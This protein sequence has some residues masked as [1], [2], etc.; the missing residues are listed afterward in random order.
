MTT[1]TNN[2]IVLAILVSLSALVSSTSSASTMVL[3]E[4]EKAVQKAGIAAIGRFST[5][6]GKVYFR[7]SEVLKGEFKTEEIEVQGI[8]VGELIDPHILLKLVKGSKFV[9][10]G[11]IDSKTGKL[12]PTFG[13]SSVWPQGVPE[14]YLK[15]EE[16]GDKI[17]AAREIV[18]IQQNK[19]QHP[20]DG[21]PVPE[22]PKE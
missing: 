3:P 12:S 16:V 14:A 15:G 22:K 6:E 11:D 1:N 10:V 13:F 8:V 17:N 7:P 5:R 9:F 21:A 19:A 18:K 20:T 2:S 4:P